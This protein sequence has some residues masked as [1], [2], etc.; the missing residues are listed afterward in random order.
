M[1]QLSCGKELTGIVLF[2]RGL[3]LDVGIHIR[4]FKEHD[5]VLSPARLEWYQ[6]VLALRHM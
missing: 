3:T 2:S 4:D 1:M 5:I 6:N